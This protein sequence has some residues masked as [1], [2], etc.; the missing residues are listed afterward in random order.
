MIDS[1]KLIDLLRQGI[2]EIQF[3][4]LK[5]NKTHSR[6]YTLHESF[7]PL[8]F[9]NQHGDKI[10]CYDVE[11]KKMEDIQINTIEKY[12]PLQKIS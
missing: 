8:K 7:M 2:V 5:S 12:V 3:R 1:E 4:S 11:F 9:Q 6:E 10:I